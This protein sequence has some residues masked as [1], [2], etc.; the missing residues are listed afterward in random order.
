MT[1]SEALDFLMRQLPMYQ[2]IGAAAYK[3][4]LGNTLALM[5]AT[6]HPELAF[7]SI[8]IAGTNGK[9]SVSHLLAAVLQESGFKTGLYTSPHMK[10][11]RERIRINGEMIPQDTVVQFVKEYSKLFSEINPSFFEMTVAMAFLHFARE[12]VDIAVI[13][14]GMGGRLDSTNV[15]DPELSVITNI[16]YDHMQFLGDSLPAIAAEKA[17]I[18]KTGKPVV[19][20][21]FLTET[22]T[23]FEQKARQNGAPIIYAQEE[24]TISSF[25]PI[26]GKTPLVA[27][28]FSLKAGP[29]FDRMTS[30]LTG[31]YQ[32]H[33]FCTSLCALYHLPDQFIPDEAAVIRGFRN[34]KT[35]TGLQ[36]RWEI[37][38]QSPFIVADTAHNLQGLQ[39]ALSQWKNIP[40]QNR[41]IVL[42][43]VNDKDI[44][45]ILR[46]FPTHALYYFCKPDVPRGLDAEQLQE[47]AQGYGLLGRAYE[48]VQQALKAAQSTANKED[49]IYIGGSTF[50]VAEIL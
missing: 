1:Y 46:L 7:R 45:G 18:I 25:T 44:S 10:D 41:H 29:A 8:H 23:V 31:N 28:D 21:E 22:R 34:V 11:F 39:E 40:A 5:E 4:D 26:P 42:G 38:N 35:L 37:M 49:A 47:V 24:S 27:F 30:P 36:G 43:V 50:V 48:S 3:A 12:E 13:E 9:G 32:R 20:G 33:N 15:V 14:T 16:G 17:G 6:G 19:I 2:R